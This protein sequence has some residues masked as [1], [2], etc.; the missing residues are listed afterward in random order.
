MRNAA[1][2]RDAVLA[3]LKDTTPKKDFGKI[4]MAAAS[5]TD[6]K[7]PSI[8]LFINDM[9]RGWYPTPDDVRA[10]L[11]KQFGGYE[12]AVDK[13]KG[14]DQTVMAVHD[15]RS[16][17]IEVVDVIT[18]QDESEGVEDSPEADDTDSA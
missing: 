14:P 16:G 7:G 4:A 6:A 2:F 5:E 13:A 12:V 9:S 17:E 18:N 11:D 10:A 8:A 3:R 1:E 15:V